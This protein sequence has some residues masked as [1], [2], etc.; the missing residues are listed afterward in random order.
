MVHVNLD[1]TL[2][3]RTRAIF[4][5]RG[6]KSLEINVPTTPLVSAWHKTP[7]KNAADIVKISSM[8]QNFD[9]IMETLVERHIQ[10]KIRKTLNRMSL[11]SSYTNVI[12]SPLWTVFGPLERIVKRIK[13]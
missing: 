10:S 11:N 3:A 2:C 1:I 5:A 13:S 9:A 6:F 12:S 8:P 7:V 4:W